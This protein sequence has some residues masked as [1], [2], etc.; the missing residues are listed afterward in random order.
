MSG[1]VEMSERDELEALLPFYLNGTLQ[2]DDLARVEAWLRDDPAAMAALAEAEAE[3]DATVLANEETAPPADALR[4][5]SRSLEAETGST[6]AT[7]GSSWLTWLLERIVGAPPALAW[8][9]AAALLAVV[10]VQATVPAGPGGQPFTEAGIEHGSERGA[11]L[12]V[13]FAP[14]AGMADIS[15]LLAEADA[16]IVAGPRPGGIYEIALADEDEAAFERLAALLDASTLV[17]RVVE[18]RR[19][20][21]GS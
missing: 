16:S 8:G 20:G 11:R 7:G 13:T 17:S 21:G 15:A 14:E 5:F 3:Q 1:P 6:P 2:G 19:P 10:V 9:V 18:G 4:R 12:L